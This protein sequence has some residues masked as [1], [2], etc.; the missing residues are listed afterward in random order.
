MRGELIDE[1]NYLKKIKSEI[2]ADKTAEKDKKLKKAE[3]AAVIMEENA[4]HE[5]IKEARRQQELRE[6]IR[7]AE[8][9]QQMVIEQEARRQAEVDARLAKIGQMM[10]HMENTVIKKQ[11]EM[12]RIAAEKLRKQQEDHAKKIE[13]EEK[14]RKRLF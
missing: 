9:R 7:L 2:E 10:G 3:E 13:D 5:V 6:D 8:L 1:S 4:K 14:E 12:D 11:L